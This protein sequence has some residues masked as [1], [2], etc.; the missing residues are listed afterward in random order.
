MGI[1]RNN[2]Q[3]REKE[4]S[5]ENVLSEIETSNFSDIKFKVMVINLLKEL[6]ENY[7]SMK[8]DTETTTKNQ[9]KM[10]TYLI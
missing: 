10:S 1:Q 8:K 7:I 2:H 9:L 3:M 6:S 4:E 5:P